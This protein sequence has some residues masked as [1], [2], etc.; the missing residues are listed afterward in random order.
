M[1]LSMIDTSREMMLDGYKNGGL[2]P[3]FNLPVQEPCTTEL[4]LTPEEGRAFLETLKS[5]GAWIQPIEETIQ[6]LACIEIDGVSHDLLTGW[7][8]TGTFKQAA[9][10]HVIRNP[11]TEVASKLVQFMAA[12][13]TS[14]ALEVD[15]SWFELPAKQQLSANDR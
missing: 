5:V 3:I 11:R 8:D 10:F 6:G 7:M 1:S 13:D 2:D 14:H 4:V 15:I 12:L 9:M